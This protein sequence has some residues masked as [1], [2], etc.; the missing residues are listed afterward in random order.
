M[1]K[2]EEFKT[3][4]QTHNGHYEYK[5]M[6]YG[7]TGG[8]GTFQGVMNEI[9]SPFLRKFVGVFID[10][11]LFYSQSWSEHLL[12]LE[13]VFTVLQQHQFHVKLSK[14]K[15]AKRELCYLGH[16]ISAAGV[17]TDPNKVES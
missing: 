11:I 2:A 13:Q 4:F 5:V 16:V 8:P 6:P 7:V 15:F 3:A 14:C 12:H 17:S 10:D 9:L 1:Q